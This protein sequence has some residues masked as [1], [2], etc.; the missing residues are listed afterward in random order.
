MTIVVTKPVGGVIPD[1]VGAT[2]ATAE[3]R[4][5]RRKLAPLVS[6]YS[7]DGKPG[8]IVAQSPKAGLTAAPG[9]EVKLVV[10]RG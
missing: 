5:R 10:G 4:L 8:R 2:L 7:T 6:A 9:L 1:V 3:K